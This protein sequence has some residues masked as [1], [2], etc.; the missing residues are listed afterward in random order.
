MY[1]NVISYILAGASAF[2]SLGCFYLA[3]IIVRSDE[4]V[5]IALPPFC[6]GFITSSFLLLAWKTGDDKYNLASFLLSATLSLAYI[7]GC[8]DNGMISGLEFLS[9]IVVVPLLCVNWIAARCLINRRNL[10]NKRFQ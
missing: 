6:Y 8:F 7:V 5:W 9:I 1:K 4:L 3:Y 10:Y 2:I